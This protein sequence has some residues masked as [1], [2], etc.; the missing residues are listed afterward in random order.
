MADKL[1]DADE[2]IDEI[3]ARKGPA[4]YTNGLSEENWEE[5]SQSSSPS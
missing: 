4:K 2:L 5:V 3:L 1:A